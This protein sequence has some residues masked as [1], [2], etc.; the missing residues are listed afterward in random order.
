MQIKTLTLV[1][2][3]LLSTLAHPSFVCDRPIVIMA[4]PFFTPSMTQEYWH[5]FANH[6]KTSLNCEVIIRPSNN[7]DKYI[8]EI[9][10]TQ[11]DILVA[12][13][14]Y[15]K[16]LSNFGFNTILTTHKNLKALLI[17]RLDIGNNPQT[18]INKTIYT[19]G[20]YSRAHFELEDWLAEQGL[21]GKVTFDSNHSHDASLTYMLKNKEASAATMGIIFD[22]LPEQIKNKYNAIEM[23]SLGAAI[24]MGNKHLNPFT[25]KAIQAAGARFT[26]ATLMSFDPSLPLTKKEIN[27][28]DRFL[29]VF[30]QRV[31]ELGATPQ[32]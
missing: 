29:N 31:K 25:I 28:E 19:P 17:S 23:S 8:T 21:K 9:I 5:G 16:A 2:I 13:S 12:P 22:R 15:Q 1:G 14:H 11:P 4:G 20:I 6:L 32:I 3:L 18:L 24:I 27:L 26:V 7:F 30:E 10:T